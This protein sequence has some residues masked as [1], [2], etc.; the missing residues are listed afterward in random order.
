ML[1]IWNQSL[2]ISCVNYVS[3]AASDVSES[4]TYTADICVYVHVSGT[5]TAYA[6]Y[7]Y[8]CR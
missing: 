3:A 1:S 4:Q 7:T 2:T 8:M 6:A 5:Y